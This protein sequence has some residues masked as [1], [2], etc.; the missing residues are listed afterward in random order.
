MQKYNLLDEQWIPLKAQSSISLYQC[1]SLS[2]KGELGGNPLQHMAVLRL[3]MAIAQ[4]ACLLEDEEEWKK[5]G[6][7]GLS[8]CCLEYLRDHYDDF[9]LYGDKP[10]L[11]DP[12]I[13]DF[14]DGAK[15]MIGVYELPQLPS[16][17]EGLMR[18]DN[19]L[20]MKKDSNLA[21]FLLLLQCYAFKSYANSE[22][23][24]CAP[25]SS[26]AF[27]KGYLYSHL[28]GKTI[29]ETIW[30]NYLTMDTLVSLYGRVSFND[31]LPPW[32]RFPSLEIEQEYTNS[33]WDW[34]I[35][36]CRRLLVAECNLIML[37]GLHCSNENS[38]KEV[39]IDPFISI[40]KQKN[41]QVIIKTE[42]SKSPWRILPA[43]LSSAYA[44]D[45][46]NCWC[47]KYC[48]SRVRKK[49]ESFSIWSGGLA[50]TPPKGVNVVMV[51]AD[52]G[53]VESSVDIMS[54]L[55]D[56]IE[57]ESF[58][59]A[60]KNIEEK[61]SIL[62]RSVF[63]F[64]KDI[65]EKEKGSKESSKAT[66]AFWSYIENEY[67]EIF[68]LCCARKSLFELFER[69]NQEIEYIYEDSCLG[70]NWRQLQARVKN[71]PF[72]RNNYEK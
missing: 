30:M 47:I 57:Y 4:R 50:V 13:I 8:K 3:L 33:I 62:Y 5:V 36:C 16:E 38:S 31:S 24:H 60:I 64:F 46:V 15:S 45:E 9:W 40:K 12:S 20:F 70:D 25:A 69:I 67:E 63:D 14:K 2:T 23:G 52:D 17:N 18:A 54:S 27:G 65:N 61:A 43:L 72:L 7:E 22:K 51:K 35:P 56:T 11:Q 71:K 39:W 49:T 29:M 26:P 21:L 48:Y 68:N 34:Y 44:G 41:E 10:F 58:C 32:E 53:F 42:Y 37:S 55:F 28:Y 1:F 66:Y 6:A 59:R 19:P